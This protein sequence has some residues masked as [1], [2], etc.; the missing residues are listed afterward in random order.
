MAPTHELADFLLGCA[1]GC[2]AAA[3]SG[4]GVMLM[5]DAMAVKTG[6]LVDQLCTAVLVV[7]AHLRVVHMNAAAEA[8]LQISHNRALG[9][10]LGQI[11]CEQNP[12]TD[13]QTAFLH[14]LNTG[15][16]YTCREAVL[17]VGLRDQRVDYSATRI[18]D[19]PHTIAD[20]ASAVGHQV[21]IEI[22]TIDRLLR[23]SRDEQLSQQHQAVRQLV[24]GVAHEINNPLGGIRGASQ[25]LSRG[26]PA[27]AA[28]QELIGIII[29]EVDRLKSLVDTLLGSHQR[30]D[31]QAVNVHEP[32]ERVLAL[33]RSQTAGQV[34][35][36]R[37]YDLSLPEVMGDCGQLVQVFLNI[38]LNAVQAMTEPGQRL[39]GPA[40]TLILRTRVQ[41]RFTIHG[42]LHRGVIRIDLEDNGPGIA[43][44][45]LESVFY[46]MVT[47]R[48]S[49]T[50][51]GLSIAQHL[52]HQH[53]GLLECQSEPGCTVFSVF[54]PWSPA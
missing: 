26:L 42:R 37:D 7:D 51:L 36:L 12:K 8:L 17:R 10:P 24:R 34:Q 31:V 9:Q 47:G 48:A 45:L 3:N 54:L 23:I 46:P 39:E 13:P 4:L 44:H 40:P 22:Q 16:P 52:V 11:F 50:G 20:A 2:L 25:L 30:P 32:L 15:H 28:Q 43:P 1:C 38:G 27:D 21:L 14:T 35:L 5:G 19:A 53:G 18:G 33:L 29:G 41:R 49:G 6:A